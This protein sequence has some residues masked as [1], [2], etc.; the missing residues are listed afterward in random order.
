MTTITT[1]FTLGLLG[2]LLGTAVL[3]YGYRLVPESARKLY[4]LLVAIPGIAIVI[5]VLGINLFGDSL[6]DVFDVRQDRGG[7]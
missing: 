6:R 4:L 5:T 3:A 1:W 2:E 7:V